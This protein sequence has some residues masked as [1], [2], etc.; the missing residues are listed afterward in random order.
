[1]VSVEDEVPDFVLEGDI[2]TFF[3]LHD[4]SARARQRLEEA[5]A[6]DRV[7]LL[8]RAWFNNYHGSRRESK[9]LFALLMLERDIPYTGEDIQAITERPPVE[10]QT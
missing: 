7:R 5:S 1:M 9:R 6:D 10:T 2:E 8:A 4:P 3:E